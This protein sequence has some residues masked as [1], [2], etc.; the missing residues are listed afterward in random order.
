MIIDGYSL[1][2]IAPYEIEFNKIKVDTEEV[3]PDELVAVTEYTAI[4]PGT[5]IA[6][7]VGAPP[8]RPGPAYPRLL[9]YCNAAKVVHTGDNAGNFKPGDRIL[10]FESHKSVFRTAKEKVIAKIPKNV[11][12]GEAVITYLLHLGYNALLRGGIKPGYNVAVIGLGVL[13]LGAVLQ[14]DLYGANVY[15][16]SNYEDRLILAKNLGA[17]FAYLKNG[18]GLEDKI[19][20]DAGETGIDLVVTTS[21]SWSDWKLALSLPRVNGTISVLGFPGRTEGLPDFNPLDSQYFYDRQLTLIA[22]GYAPDYLI[23]S[24]DIRFTIKRNMEFLLSLIS[25][26][27]ILPGN[28][29]SGVFDFNEIEKAYGNLISG[30]ES[31]ITYVLR[32]F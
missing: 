12:S 2:L 22:S 25:D 11:E 27:K 30:K 28:L 21:N 1:L 31:P 26:G 7:Y 3:L 4:S 5:E 19:R 18:T 10:T 15:S 23:D 9:G 32:W 13:G 29:I 17:K 14:A 8:L 6:A 16:F 24:K 20:Q